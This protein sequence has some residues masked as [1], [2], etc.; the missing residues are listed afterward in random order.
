MNANSLPSQ[1]SSSLVSD[2]S[3]ESEDEDVLVSEGEGLEEVD[4]SA[5]RRLMASAVE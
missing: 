2:D 4:E 5:P 3:N 1:Q